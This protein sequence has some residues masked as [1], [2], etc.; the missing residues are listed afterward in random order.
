[1]ADYQY[2][3]EYPHDGAIYE[4]TFDRDEAIEALVWAMGQ[5]EIL[6]AMED[7][8]APRFDNARVVVREREDELDEWGPW[9]LEDVT[10]A[11]LRDAAREYDG[12]V[13]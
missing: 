4:H 9:A 7:W 8:E 2:A 5:R 3:V 12:E 10:E 13:D 11:E 6:Y 1:V